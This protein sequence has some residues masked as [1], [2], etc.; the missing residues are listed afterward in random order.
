MSDVSSKL[1]EMQQFWLQLPVALC[2]SKASSSRD[3]CWNGMTK[4]RYRLRFRLS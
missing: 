2:R 1:K 3:R 4:A